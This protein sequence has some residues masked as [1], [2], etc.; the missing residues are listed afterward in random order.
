MLVLDFDCRALHSALLRWE[1]P[2]LSAVSRIF[3][4]EKGT[5]DEG[6]FIRAAAE[7]DR[8]HSRFANVTGPGERRTVRISRHW[9]LLPMTDRRF[10]PGSHTG[11]SR[12]GRVFLARTPIIGDQYSMRKNKACVT[13]KLS[14]KREQELAAAEGGLLTTRQCREWHLPWPQSR[15]QTQS[16]LAV[17]IHDQSRLRLAQ[18]STIGK[19]SREEHQSRHRSLG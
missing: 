18:Q 12:Q 16:R 8:L 15:D 14:S 10:D 2:E 1:F 5:E 11:T 3:A 13:T 19:L 7:Y 4:L 17:S 9:S 6:S